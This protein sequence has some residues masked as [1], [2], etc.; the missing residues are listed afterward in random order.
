MSPLEQIE[1]GR[2]VSTVA[3]DLREEHVRDGGI[4]G[5]L[6]CFERLSAMRP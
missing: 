1:R 4:A 5:V 6:A 2:R 3:L